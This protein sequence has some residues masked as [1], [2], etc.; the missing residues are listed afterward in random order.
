MAS[1]TV[2]TGANG[3]GLFIAL[4]GLALLIFKRGDKQ[5][6][7]AGKLFFIFGIGLTIATLILG[8]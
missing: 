4:F 2:V 1:A 5:T 8:F 7:E 6:A 3:S